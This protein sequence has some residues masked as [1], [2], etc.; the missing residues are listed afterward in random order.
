MHMNMIVLIADREEISRN[1][2]EDNEG[3][4]EERN[5]YQV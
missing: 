4:L 2:T 1:P 5:N 3:K